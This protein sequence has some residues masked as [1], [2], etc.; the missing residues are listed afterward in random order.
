[1]DMELPSIDYCMSVEQAILVGSD[2]ATD[3]EHLY[4]AVKSGQVPMSR[5]D[6]M[7]YRSGSFLRRAS[8]DG[9]SIL[10]PYLAFGQ[11]ASYPNTNW[12]KFDLADEIEV[13][14]KF[15]RNQHIDNKGDNYL[16]ARKVAAESTVYVSRLPLYPF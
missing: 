16:F 1:M 14:G 13:G 5:L 10:T 4:K 7:A 9:P 8:T 12:Q 6:D 15:F 11:N 3:G 2:T